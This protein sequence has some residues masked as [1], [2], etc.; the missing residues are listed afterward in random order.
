MFTDGYSD[1]WCATLESSGGLSLLSLMF[2]H[3]VEHKVGD[4]GLALAI[5]S[6][7]TAALE[8][9]SLTLQLQ[10]NANILAILK[11][12][13]TSCQDQ[14]GICTL[15]V[16]LEHAITQPLLHFDKD[17][18][19]FIFLSDFNGVIY[20][21]KLLTLI[22]DC[23]TCWQNGQVYHLGDSLTCQEAV[24]TALLALVQD[25]QLFRDVNV[26][27][28]RQ[29][30]FVKRLAYI[31]K[32]S[33][34]S[35][36]EFCHMHALIIEIFSAL[37]G[38]PPDLGVINE[39]VQVALF[40]HDSTHTYVHHARNSFYFAI[41]PMLAKTSPSSMT[42]PRNASRS[43]QDRSLLVKS[44]S[45]NDEDGLAAKA[46]AYSQSFEGPEGKDLRCQN[47]TDNDVTSLQNT[48]LNPKRLSKVLRQH[49]KKNPNSSKRSILIGSNQN[50]EIQQ[51]E[52]HFG[53]LSRLDGFDAEDDDD[54]VDFSM[55]ENRFPQS[56][57]EGILEILHGALLNM[58]DTAVSTA[59]MSII[60][61]E[62]ILVLV[63]HPDPYV[64]LAAI[65]VM[66]KYV[67]RTCSGNNSD[68]YRINKICGF[69]LLACQISS[70]GCISVP[71]V[72]ME[73]TVSAL[74]SLV[75]GVDVYSTSNIPELPARGASIR[76]NF[77][78]PILALLPALA[79]SGNTHLATT[80]SV[81]VH[82]HDI[83]TKVQ[84]FVRKEHQTLGLFEALSH[85][86]AALITSASSLWSCDMFGKDGRDILFEDLDHLF[87]FIGKF[88]LH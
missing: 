87:K 63:N 74:L 9:C 83:I 68:G 50:N 51:N 16:L 21:G 46:F 35:G 44:A 5:D 31:L 12:V 2:F 66:V 61:P 36:E 88:R 75:H 1:S 73:K 62:Y 49:T 42:W 81:I 55:A 15:R 82:L 7:L 79:A 8:E 6:I 85:T 48:K 32:S 76:A 30:D 80:H 26:Q 58:P 47:V 69:H 56:V 84:N 53:H 25:T 59:K 45:F 11:K 65:R 20:N 57:I 13:M 41:L 72:V 23:W 86:M 3:A 38:S 40:L 71:S 10:E 64:R 54:E 70:W 22:I 14:V 77:L 28:L 17:Y 29:L 19:R 78:A 37:V 43:A 52:I 39:L 33:F 18:A 34:E 27:S 24:L 60:L 67:Q 4:A